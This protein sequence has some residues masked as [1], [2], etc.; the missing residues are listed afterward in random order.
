[1]RAKLINKIM[2]V[3][4][5]KLPIYDEILVCVEKIVQLEQKEK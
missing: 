5:D 3:S 4:E 1:M 2:T